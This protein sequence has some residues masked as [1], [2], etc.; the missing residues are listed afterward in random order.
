[1]A[2]VGLS[3]SIEYLS[4]AVRIAVEVETSHPRLDSVVWIKAARWFFGW[5]KRRVFDDGRFAARDTRNKRVR[6]KCIRGSLAEDDFVVVTRFARVTGKFVA[7]YV[8]EL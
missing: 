8:N 6:D 5:Y 7:I 4:D 2:I 3:A 1:M